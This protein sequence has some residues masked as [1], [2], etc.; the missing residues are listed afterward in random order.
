MAIQAKE[1]GVF[2]YVALRIDTLIKETICYDRNHTIPPCLFGGVLYFKL[3][4]NLIY[5]KNTN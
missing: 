2:L 1:L 5:K 3:S 4:F